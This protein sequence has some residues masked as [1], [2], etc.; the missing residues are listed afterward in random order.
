MNIKS[1]KVTR[2]LVYGPDSYIDWCNEEGI[3]PT[4]EGFKEFISDWIYEDF[5][6]I[7]DEFLDLKIEED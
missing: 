3:I 2:T 4:Q 7:E 6:L 5:N 1:I